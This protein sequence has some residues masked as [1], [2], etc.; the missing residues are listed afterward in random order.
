M[1][2]LIKSFLRL[3]LF[4]DSIPIRNIFYR[5]IRNLINV[6]YKIFLTFRPFYRYCLINDFLIKKRVSCWAPSGSYVIYSKLPSF[7]FVQNDFWAKNRI[8]C[9]LWK[10]LCSRMRSLGPLK[11]CCGV[12]ESGNHLTHTDTHSHTHTHTTTQTHTN[13]HFHTDRHTQTHLH[14]H[15]HTHTHTTQT[16]IF[17]SCT[18]DQNKAHPLQ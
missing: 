4:L 12:D 15:T 10:N 3:L 17:R 8:S 13:S 5:K 18:L 9:I 1:V 16:H 6:I 7:N 11:S 2:L 14:T